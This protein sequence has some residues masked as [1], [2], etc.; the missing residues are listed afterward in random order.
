MQTPQWLKWGLLV[1]IGII[2]LANSQSEDGQPSRLSMAFDNIKNE[3]P[4]QVQYAK[5][6]P[7]NIKLSSRVIKEGEGAFVLCG[8]DMQVDYL[9]YREQEKVAA[10]TR[11]IRMFPDQHASTLLPLI[12]GARVG[13][14]RQFV[15]EKPTLVAKWFDAE[16][17]AELTHFDLTLIK[18]TPDSRGLLDGDGLGIKLFDEKVGQGKYAVCGDQVEVSYRSYDRAGDMAQQDSVAF[19]IGEGKVIAGLEQGV[20]GMQKGASRTLILAP[21]WQRH[22]YAHQAPYKKLA[23]H[24]QLMVLEVTREK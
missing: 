6:L 18:A 7:E 16:E 1:F 20:I 3:L 21:K 14:I 10:G 12:A 19:A 17:G 8:Q 11:T 22:F 4:N 23:S 24:N 9:A 13:E 2:F 5:L 15:S